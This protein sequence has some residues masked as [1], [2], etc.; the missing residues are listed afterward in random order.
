MINDLTAA[1]CPLKSDDSPFAELIHTLTVR[2]REAEANRRPDGEKA[3]K[4]K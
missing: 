4:D 3:W 1:E 2:S